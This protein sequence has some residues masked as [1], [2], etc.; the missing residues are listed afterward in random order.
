LSRTITTA[1]IAPLGDD[2]ETR[3]RVAV[4]QLE[5]LVDLWRR[6]MRSPLPISPRTS[7]AWAAAVAQ[8]RDADGTVHEAAWWWNSA[9]KLDKEDKSAEQLLVLGG[10]RPLPEL[11]VASGAPE[12]DERGAGWA[13]SESSRFGL[14][15]R[16]LWDGLLAHEE[17]TDR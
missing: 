8:G 9:Y 10:Q 16:R 4:E 17:L 7:A 1:H 11:I 6:G 5:I 13:A 12:P 3:R 2:A 14:Y 15:A